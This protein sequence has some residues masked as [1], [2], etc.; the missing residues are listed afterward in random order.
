[1][2]ALLLSSALIIISISIVHAQQSGVTTTGMNSTNTQETDSSD[3]TLRQ[4]DNKLI[5]QPQPELVKLAIADVSEALKQT[6]NGDKAYK[7]WENSVISFYQPDNEYMIVLS[8]N[9]SAKATTYYFNSEG[10][11]LRK[12]KNKKG[13]EPIKRDF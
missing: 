5:P 1:M 13:T 11:L 7:G 10:K 2:K 12:E 4:E 6:L 8:D 3:L 9:R